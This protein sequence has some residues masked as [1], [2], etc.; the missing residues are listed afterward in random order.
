MLLKPAEGRQVRDPEMR[1]LLPAE[2]REVTRNTYWLRRLRDGDVIEMTAPAA[3]APS[4]L[5][6]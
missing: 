6:A 4:T 1:D 5:K 2:G 3:P